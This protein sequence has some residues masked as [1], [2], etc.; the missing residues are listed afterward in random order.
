MFG[1][2]ARGATGCVAGC[3]ATVAEWW[4]WVCGCVARC[5]AGCVGV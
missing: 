1:C 3:V 4:S 2:I 5:V